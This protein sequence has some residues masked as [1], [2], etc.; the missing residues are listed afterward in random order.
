M[1]IY[2]GRDSFYQWDTNQQ[3]THEN[4]SVGDEVHVYSP[5]KTSALVVLAYEMDDGKVVADVPNI[6]LQSHFPITVYRILV[7]DEGRS[8]LDE[9]QFQ[10][11]KRAKPTDYVYTETEVVDY[12]NLDRRLRALEGEGLAQAIADY[13]EE[14][15]I[16]AGATAAEAA[17]I[18]QNK[19][20]IEKLSV[21]KLD[22]SKLPEAVNDA[23][24]QAKASGE[25]DGA[26]GKDGEKGEKGDPGEPGKDGQDGSP[27]KDG[28][29]GKDYILTEADKQEIAELASELVDVP[30]L[31][32]PLIGTTEE[33]TPTQVLE[34]LSQGRVVAIAH[35]DERVG[36]IA[37][38]G[39]YTVYG[40]VLANGLLP[41]D[42]GGAAVTLFGVVDSAEWFLGLE[43]LP[44]KDDIPTDDHINDLIDAAIDNLEIPEGGTVE[45]KPLT[46]T[47]A[48][49]A[50]YDGSEPVAVNIPAAVTD[51]HINQLI[52]TALG[53]IENGTY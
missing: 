51:D 47:G 38:N 19:Q 12:R 4:L 46:F 6:L 39:F 52:N 14:N 21:D 17:Q 42:D 3:V 53:V 50:T 26:P 30:D 33:I 8:T 29:D 27:G 32:E 23:L 35:T 28:T 31:A 34:A 18:E 10:V 13:L 11:K 16:E 2:N 1:Q 40:V 7:D 37:F 43:T 49:N 44:S 22:S 41:K 45:M 24:A 20:S 9:Y 5:M 48:V 25:F 15:P 36:T